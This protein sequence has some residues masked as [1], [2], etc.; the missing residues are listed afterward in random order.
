MR[1][2][3]VY[4]RDGDTRRLSHYA[5]LPVTTYTK[6]DGRYHKETRWLEEVEY[7]QRYRVMMLSRNYWE[8]TR[9]ID[10]EGE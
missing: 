8:N 1:S 4:P 3:K 9:F 6:I 2:K 5:W 7:E 10:T